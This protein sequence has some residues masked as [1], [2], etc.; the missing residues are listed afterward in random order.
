MDGSRQGWGVLDLVAGSLARIFDVCWVFVAA[1]VA[2]WIRFEHID[3]PLPFQAVMVIGALL[4]MLC[5]AGF[6]VY[7]SWRGRRKIHLIGCLLASYV[8]SW[9]I[10]MGLL[11]VSH[12]AGNYSRLWFGFW[13][14]T[15]LLGSTAFRGV[16]YFTLSRIRALGYNH[17]R[18]II[19]GSPCSIEKA[20]QRICESPWLGMILHKIL[21]VGDDQ[22]C[23]LMFPRIQDV[24][25]LS[26]AVSKDSVHEVWICLPLRE[27]QRINDVLF[28][29]RHST[30]N[31]RYFPDLSGYR[32]LN[33]KATEVAGLNVLDLSCSPLDGLNRFVKNLED[34]IL[35][36]IIF[37]VI[38]P[39]LALIAVGVKLSSPGPI[40]FKQY[41]HGMDGRRINVYKFRSMKIHQEPK[42]IITQARRE[43][44]RITPFGRFLRRTSLDEL[45]QFFNVIQ[46]KMSIV[47]PR[48]HA[49]AHNEKY[50]ELVESYMKRHKVKP[51]ITGW[52]QVNGL[53]GETDTLDKMQKRV[54]YDLFYIENWSLAFDLRI[55][56]M[57]LWRGFVNR[58][59]F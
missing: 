15:A 11:V 8:C 34:R 39:L 52:A 43:D 59:A 24:S 25:N 46:G 53:R 26:E 20:Y 3:I 31:I 23:A 19:V 57:T 13:F 17:K 54:E 16:V 47:G 37:V 58:N 56:V 33:H 38:V 41:R 29:L 36:L 48:P 42:G 4:V 50:K 6:S 44:D 45:P 51:G 10:L 21:I 55:I 30:T 2:Y 7:R 35:G 1:V 5:S 32:L 28:E 49:L 9:S 12:Q 22:K 18:V 14:V 27:E 40:I